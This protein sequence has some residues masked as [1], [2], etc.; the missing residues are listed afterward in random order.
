MKFRDYI[1][2]GTNTLQQ[3]DDT[4][5]PENKVKIVKWKGTAY[6]SDYKKGDTGYFAKNKSGFIY[7]PISGS[8]ADSYSDGISI[9]AVDVKQ[10]GDRIMAKKSGQN[11]EFKKIGR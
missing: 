11:F 2:E 4:M 5:K 10:S 9:G 3:R 6:D 8:A 1:N 7:V